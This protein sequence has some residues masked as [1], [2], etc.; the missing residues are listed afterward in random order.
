MIEKLCLT[1]V[2]LGGG[3]TTGQATSLLIYSGNATDANHVKTLI[4]SVGALPAD[5]ELFD[6]GFGTPRLDTLQTYESVL[7]WL[8]DPYFDAVAIG[9]NLADYVD[10]GGGVVVASF[11]NVTGE[12][13]GRF[14]SGGYH[15][16]TPAAP[17]TPVSGATMTVNDPNHPIMLAVTAFA[18]GNASF[19]ISGTAAA[20]TTKIAD[21]DN[22][23]PLVVERPQGGGGA[24]GIVIGLNMFPV[25]SA[26][27][28]GGWDAATDGAQ[29]MANSLK[30]AGQVPE[31]SS[32]VFVAMGMVLVGRRR[33]ALRKGRGD[34]VS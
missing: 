4:D 6:A 26:E 14:L 20:G 10:G 11:A 8:D 27:N 34:K 22:G 1:F 16:I 31:P 25:S 33:R 15:P 24:G 17:S 12:L 3:L 13:G 7:I 5:V 2:L 28:I 32:A 18:G 23:Q 19:R 9:D 29:L 21:W 30:F